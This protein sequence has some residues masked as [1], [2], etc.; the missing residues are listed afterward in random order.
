MEVIKATTNSRATGNDQAY[1]YKDM[2]ATRD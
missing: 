2:S 1:S